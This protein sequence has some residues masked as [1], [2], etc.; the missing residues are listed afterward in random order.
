MKSHS[1]YKCC[2]GTDEY[3]IEHT[4]D[5]ERLIWAK[6]LVWDTLSIDQKRK[7]LEKARKQLLKFKNQGFIE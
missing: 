5:C 1:P 4:Q 3:P 7:L 6:N 2:G